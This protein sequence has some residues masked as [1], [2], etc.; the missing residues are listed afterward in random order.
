MH[1]DRLCKLALI[2]TKTRALAIARELELDPKNGEQPVRIHWSGCPAGC[3]N[4]QVADIGLEGKRI[5]RNG[6]VVEAVDVYVGGRSGPGGRKGKRILENISC[7]DLLPV[8]ERLIRSDVIAV[9]V[10]PPAHEPKQPA[11]RTST[12]S[13]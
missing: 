8:L 3:G 7:D 10:D 9:S 13:A 11:R 5:R 2:D 1:R 4:H 12:A 6:D